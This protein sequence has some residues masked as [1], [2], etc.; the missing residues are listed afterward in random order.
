MHFVLNS[1]VLKAQHGGHTGQPGQV[2]SD[3]RSGVFALTAVKEIS[4]DIKFVSSH[5]KMKV[6]YCH[7]RAREFG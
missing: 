2:H 1:W 3:N 6:H 4:C 7:F 5:P